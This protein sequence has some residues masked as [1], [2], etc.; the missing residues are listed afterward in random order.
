MNDTRLEIR[1][2]AQRRRELDELASEVGLSAADLTRLSIRWLLEHRD[3]LFKLP[4][5][6]PR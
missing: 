4:T 2:P 1:M 3:A 5:G 6:E